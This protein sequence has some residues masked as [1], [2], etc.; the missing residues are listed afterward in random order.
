MIKIRYGVFET[1]SSSVHAMVC[2]DDDEYKALCEGNLYVSWSGD[3]ITKE[4]AIQELEKDFAKNPADYESF[5]QDYID[6]DGNFLYYPGI[7][8]D[9]EKPVLDAFAHEFLELNTYEDY[10][11]NEYY[12]GYETTYTTK[13]GENIHIFGYSGRDG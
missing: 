11:N 12:E 6:C 13:G 7:F 4:E 1:N 9:L 10:V 8:N 2:C 5:Y 3:F